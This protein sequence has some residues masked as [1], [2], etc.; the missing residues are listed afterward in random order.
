MKEEGECDFARVHVIGLEFACSNQK[1]VAVKWS[2]TLAQRSRAE[3][4][5]TVVADGRG[6]EVE[7]LIQGLFAKSAIRSVVIPKTV[8]FL[9]DKCFEFCESLCE[10]VFDRA[11]RVNY[12]GMCCFKKCGL[13]EFDLPDSCVIIGEKCFDGCAKLCRIRISENSEL[14]EIGSFAFRGCNIS[15]LYLP[16]RFDISSCEGVFLGVKSFVL[17]KNIDLVVSDGFIL[18]KDKENLLHCFSSNPVVE[19][20]D[21]IERISRCCFAGSNVRKVIF[22]AKSKI[23]N[24]TGSFTGSSVE[25]IVFKRRNTKFVI[26]G[27]AV[28]KRSNEG[29]DTLVAQMT[30]QSELFVRASV[31]TV[32]QNCCLHPESLKS[33]KFDPN[34]RDVQMK[35]GA[36]RDT[37]LA[38]ALLAGVTTVSSKCFFNCKFLKSLSFSDLKVS[39][40]KTKAF[41]MCGLESLCVPKSVTKIGDKCFCGCTLLKKLDFEEGSCLKTIGE[42]AFMHT[43]LKQLAVPSSVENV[44]GTS[45]Y[46]VKELVLAQEGFLT[47][48]NGLLILQS[49]QSLVSVISFTGTDIVIPFNIRILGRKSFY[50][51]GHVH[52]VSFEPDS[53]LSAIEDEAFQ[54]CEVDELYLP[55]CLSSIGMN[56]TEHAKQIYVCDGSEVIN[57]CGEF[58]LTRLMKTS[59]ILLNTQR[60]KDVNVIPDYINTISRSCFSHRR[61]GG[62]ALSFSPSELCEMHDFQDKAF[63][64]SD[65]VSIS[66]PM[67]TKNI[68]RSCFEACQSLVSIS[69]EPWCSVTSLGE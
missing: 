9:P 28:Y 32:S 50:R 45:F 12:L 7:I 36:F 38:E 52:S 43:A 41:S 6:H 47:I 16:S 22:G 17:G 59:W 69:F 15:N 19:V 30:N 20:P 42:K 53:E 24:I 48:H 37:R 29:T 66:I 58:Y 64:G 10:A 55:R 63:K 60:T 57:V 3:I 51:C 5:E 26:E 40:F 13:T 56:V 23:D 34:C 65:I 49:T 68:G 8:K 14:E 4:P 67:S 33:V 31:C 11:S 25:G 35:D 44:K 2:P 1:A 46:G 18:S 61:T 21:S 54:Y 27:G 39:K 62:F